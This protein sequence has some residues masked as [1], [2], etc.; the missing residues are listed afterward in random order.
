MG[1]HPAVY[2]TTRPVQP[3]LATDL[4]KVRQMQRRASLLAASTMIWRRLPCKLSAATL[5]VIASVRA[6]RMLLRQ[7]P[8]I[9]TLLAA[10]LLAAH[11]AERRNVAWPAALRSLTFTALQPHLGPPGLGESPRSLCYS[12]ASQARKSLPHCLGPSSLGESPGSVCYS[13]ASQA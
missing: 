2:A 11:Q 5:L 13:K 1:S 3:G 12:K 4:T 6:W 7:W 9:D 10:A 8:C